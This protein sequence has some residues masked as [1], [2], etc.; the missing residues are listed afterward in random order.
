MQG[1]SC[2]DDS[3]DLLNSK[4][5]N[6]SIQASLDG[7]SVLLQD[8]ETHS[9]MAMK[10]ESYKLSSENGLLRKTHEI[11]QFNNLL[12]RQYNKVTV[13]IDS[14]TAKLI[15]GHLVNDKQ[16]KHLFS[17]KPKD[18]RGK[19][20]F[21]NAI[22]QSYQL[23]F[24]CSSDVVE[25][26]NTHFGSCEFVHETTPLIKKNIHN[27]VNETVNINLF[28]HSDYYYISASKKNEILFFNS[29]AFKTPEDILFYLFSAIRLLDSEKC[30]IFLS[31]Y[32]DEQDSTYT[33]IKKYFPEAR[34][35]SGKDH[36]FS[37]GQF[38]QMP[39]HKIT[40]ILSDT[41]LT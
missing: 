38:N 4:R 35:I 18:T 31:G 12:N 40:P 9:Y 27:S 1:T 36:R 37:N 30:D 16:L 2:Y 10:H 15:P 14:N 39:V 20:F 8:G 32:I 5:Y 13:F 3:F 22:N 41:L 33:I 28:F 6:L 19:S 24:A 11:L 17:I 25:F 29:F 26:F 34:L 21:A 7:F 23:V